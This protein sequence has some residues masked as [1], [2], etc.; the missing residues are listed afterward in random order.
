MAKTLFALMD[1]YIMLIKKSPK[2]YWRCTQRKD[3]CP[4]RAISDSNNKNFEETGEHNHV[5]QNTKVTVLKTC[6]SI[7]QLAKKD[8]KTA[9]QVYDAE[10]SKLV[11]EGDNEV[12]A[13]MPT[14]KSLKHSMYRYVIFC[15]LSC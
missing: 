3:K 6:H 15:T 14:Y 13:Q 11:L 5:R 8:L 2:K 7:K 1:S 4:G 9:P 12:I 10:R